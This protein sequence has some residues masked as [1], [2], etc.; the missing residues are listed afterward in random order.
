M[1]SPMATSMQRTSVTIRVPATTANLGPGYDVLGLALNLWL[2]VKATR[3]DTFS[4]KVSGDG[5]E[6]IELDESKNLIVQCVKTAFEIAEQPYPPIAYEIHSDIPF[7]CGC[8]SS[9]AAAVAGAMVGFILC[10]KTL[11]VSREEA[12]L[13]VATKIEGHPDNAAPCLYGGLQIGMH[14]GSRFVTHRVPMPNS[15][16]CVLFVPAKKMKKHTSE[17]RKL[18]PTEVSMKDAI[19]NMSRTALLVLALSTSQLDLLKECADDRFHQQQRKVM[20]PHLEPCIDAAMAAGAVYTFLSGAGPSV[21]AFVPGR[22][23]ETIIMDPQQRLCEDV[24]A[25]MVKAAAGA[26]V[27]GRCVVTH[28]SETGA[29][30]TGLEPSLSSSILKFPAGL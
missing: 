14:N 22:V 29:H 11:M 26:G 9:S 6:A 15:L 12:M 4:M 24:A 27:E 1:A 30:V 25:A 23:G 3:A 2:T 16:W 13:Q 19:H 28:P 10:G 18:I 21:C 5:A 20:F 8:G 7:G 17:T